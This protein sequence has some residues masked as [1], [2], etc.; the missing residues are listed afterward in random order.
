[1]FTELLEA[2]VFQAIEMKNN[3][4]YCVIVTFNPSEELL[5]KVTKSIKINTQN[6]IIINNGKSINLFENQEFEKNRINKLQQKYR[7]RIS[8]KFRNSNSKKQ[9][10]RI[11]MWLIA[12]RIQFIQTLYPP[13]DA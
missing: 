1:M 13:N 12:T 11:H 2:S 3:N 7:D 4:I 8:S 10:R 5:L 6:I 9:G